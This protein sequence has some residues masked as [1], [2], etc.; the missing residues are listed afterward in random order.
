[1]VTVPVLGYLLIF[2][3]VPNSNNTAS[4]IGTIARCSDRRERNITTGLFGLR[5]ALISRIT[6]T[7]TDAL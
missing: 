5:C 4:S 3:G 6:Y 1:M 7:D 2:R